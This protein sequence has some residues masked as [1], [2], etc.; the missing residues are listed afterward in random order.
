MIFFRLVELEVPPE[1]T[2][3]AAVTE[4]DV[5]S[6]DSLPYQLFI[7]KYADNLTFFMN[8]NLI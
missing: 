2:Q 8:I 1:E 6:A 3:E 5:K 4:A 7:Q